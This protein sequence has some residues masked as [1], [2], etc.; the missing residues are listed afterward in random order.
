VTGLVLGPCAIP[1]VPHVAG[2]HTSTGEELRADLVLDAMG[3][4]SG[5]GLLTAIG[6]REPHLDRAL[7]PPGRA[8]PR[9]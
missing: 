1:G 3:R 7:R 8:S 4:R 5:A 2:V 9:P 6:A